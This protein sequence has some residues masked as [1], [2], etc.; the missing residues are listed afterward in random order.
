M[1]ATGIIPLRFLHS[2]GANFTLPIQ[3]KPII[4]T[5]FPFSLKKVNGKDAKHEIERGH[6]R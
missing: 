3:R 4:T 5:L 6:S 1:R 2:F